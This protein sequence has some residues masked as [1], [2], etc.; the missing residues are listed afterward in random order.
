MKNSKKPANFHRRNPLS[1]FPSLQI[2]SGYFAFRKINF[3]V[4]GI[5]L[6]LVLWLPL[7]FGQVH[8][9]EGQV[10]MQDI[11][12]PET[13]EIVDVKRTEERKQRVLEDLPPVYII[14][15]AILDKSRADIERFFEDLD[16]IRS[17][18]PLPDGFREEHRTR[19]RMTDQIHEWFT[20]APED[21]YLFV[22][23][24]FLSG[25]ERSVSSPIREDDIA[26]ILRQAAFDLDMTQLDPEENRVVSFLM[27][28]FVRPNARIDPILTEAEHAR[29]LSEVEPVKRLILR[30]QTLLRR[31]DVANRENMEILKALNITGDRFDYAYL[32]VLALIIGLA[33]LCEFL[34]IRKFTPAILGDSNLLLIRIL[35]VLGVL[36]LG[37]ITLQF[38][39]YFIMLGA[40]PL[41]LHTLMG[42]VF[43]LGECLIL[44]P[45]L[46]WAEQMD[47]LRG[48]YLYLNLL[49]PLLLLGPNINRQ[50]LVRAGFFLSLTNGAVS[51]IFGY[52]ESL[53]FLPTFSNT[54]FGIGGGIGAAV[55]A[56]G[57]ISLFENTFYLSTNIRLYEMLN[58]THPLLKRLMMEAPGTYSHS[59]VVANLAEAAAEEV[60]ANPLLARAGAYYH[61]IG[62]LKRP[63]FFIENQLGAKNIHNRLSPNLSSLIIQSHVKDGID[64]ARQYRLPKEIKEI[65]ARHHGTNLIRFFYDKALRERR[66]PVQ[67]EQF[68]YA[69]LHPRTP[70]EVLIFLADSVEA[71][72]RCMSRSTSS[73]IETVV[74]NILQMY[75]KDGQLDESN[76]TL[77]DLHI[78]TRTFLI[79][80]S[81][82]VH[83]RIP[84]PEKSVTKGKRPDSL[85]ENREIPT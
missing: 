11:V 65:I 58:P 43:A 69:G 81:G 4:Y 72:T 68:R 20:S 2:L 46:I 62:K 84:Y 15:Q 75:L 85:P 76:L 54:L 44:I 41:L 71:A 70:E 80:L 83:A 67:E 64:I 47:Y 3:F 21:R 30:D 79:V 23:R 33:I 73:R 48:F 32:A 52:H 1:V 5:A 49:L 29:I 34:F 14:D 39:W 24:T 7:T 13:V 17:G 26:D 74:N 37:H 59:L 51:F 8:V 55:M 31:G 9:V 10:V 66:D 18:D 63:Y 61:D 36:F 6:F 27:I 60:G 28:W 40:I 77:K 57:G 42:R 78:I 50:S 82:M 35:S 25:Y 22:R 19:Y 16:R 38:S 45:L 56:L 53:N 12:A